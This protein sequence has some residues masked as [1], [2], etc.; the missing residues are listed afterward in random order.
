MKNLK[1]YFAE[2][3]QRPGMYLGANSISKLFDHLQGYQMTYWNNSIVNSEDTH[4]FENF[5]D[6]V[7]RYYG[8]TSNENWKTVILTQELN[9]EEDALITFFN[10]FDSFMNNEK[11]T[12]TKNIVINLFDKF[13]FEQSEMKN[14]FGNNFQPVLTEIIGLIKDYAITGFKSDYD[15]IFEQLNELAEQ[16]P[17]LKKILSDPA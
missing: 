12:N 10:L 4:F 5:N 17:E 11:I 7:Y 3:R 9:S 1:D 15:N 14:Q 6:F 2:I 16:I 13:I 8:L